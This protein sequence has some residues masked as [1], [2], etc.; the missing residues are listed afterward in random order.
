MAP[1]AVTRFD[2]TVLKVTNNTHPGSFQSTFCVLSQI[3]C[4]IYTMDF[5]NIPRGVSGY[6]DA[7]RKP[8]LF[9]LGF[10]S[11]SLKHVSHLLP[12]R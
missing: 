9:A 5:Q 3:D 7:P 4:E 11:K 10:E 8:V 6:M 12:C 1:L 2:Q